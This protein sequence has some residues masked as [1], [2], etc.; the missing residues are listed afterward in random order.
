M[1]API[2]SIQSLRKS[3][4]ALKATDDVN[5]DVENSE[6]HA[7]IG[8][9]GAGKTTL[10]AQICG[11][12][13][14]DSGT[15]TFNGRDITH[16]PDTQRPALGLARSFQITS[17]FPQF[18]VLENVMAAAQIQEGNSYRLLPS[19]RANK[20]LSEAALHNLY[21]VGL[22]DMTNTT[23]DAMSHGQKRH[24][25]LAMALALK[26]KM[27][28]LDE[29]LAGMGPK[30]SEGIVEM[31]NGMKKDYSI[32]LVEHD[33]DAVFALADRIS[34]LVYGRVIA[35]GATEDIRN[36]AGVRTA[37]LGED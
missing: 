22:Q 5:I 23:A 6:L 36:D 33:M 28:V 37:Y 31:L 27:L 19:A 30:E 32:L 11:Q 35:C 15:I 17:I 3:F 10:I 25:E 1:T 7:V 24:L 26:P 8:P 12:L 29:P 2:L 21:L 16:M 18:T 20:R 4:G 13:A 14:P 34:V 9:N